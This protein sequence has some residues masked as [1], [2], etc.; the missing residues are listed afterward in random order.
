MRDCV[1]VLTIVHPCFADN[2]VSVRGGYELGLGA[3]RCVYDE[4]RVD[5]EL[6]FCLGLGTGFGAVEEDARC[7]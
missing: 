7:A 5:V 4:A 6:L 2:P 3:F 1:D